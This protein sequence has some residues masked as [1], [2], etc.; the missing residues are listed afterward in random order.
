MVKGLSAILP[1][2]KSMALWL[3]ELALGKSK[4]ADSDD[5]EGCD[6]CGR[7]HCLDLER[8]Q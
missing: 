2:C 6:Y 1:N 5:P 7:H 3:A 4:G 8:L